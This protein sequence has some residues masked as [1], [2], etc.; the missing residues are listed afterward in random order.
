MVKISFYE[1][2][3]N[4]SGYLHCFTFFKTFWKYQLILT[5]CF[6]KRLLK[7]QLLSCKSLK[8]N[9]RDENMKITVLL[10]HKGLERATGN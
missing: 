2:Y 7:R 5:T 9:L 1:T 8:A 4:D 10:S 3:N 6:Q